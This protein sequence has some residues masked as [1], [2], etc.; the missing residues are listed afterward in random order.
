MVLPIVALVRPSSLATATNGM[1]PAAALSDVGP[2]GSL[3]I[4]AARAWKALCAAAK[5]AGWN[6]TYTYGG[7]YRPYADQERLFLSRYT[8]TF[9]PAAN[10]TVDSRMWRGARW[11]KRLGVAAAASPGTSNHGWGLAVDAALDF[12]VTD[13]IG[14]DDAVAITPALT[15][16]IANAQRF[17]WSWELQSEPW[18]IR[19]VAGDKVPQ[20]VLDYEAGQCFIAPLPYDPP[21]H[22]FGDWPQ[23]PKPVLSKG[24]TGLEV[25]YLQDVLRHEA[26][27]VIVTD[28][29]FGPKTEAEVI[30]FQ[31][32]FSI[33]ADGVVADQTWSAVD[34]I[35]SN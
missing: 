35:A 19:Y 33:E 4:T 15:W 16:L 31:R 34:F 14:P 5:I 11:Y 13:G 30:E 25:R 10:A 28:G 29:N 22:K 6:L 12:D 20:A 2:R 32:F 23:R 18:H 21:N 17:G 9:D 1:L 26:N 3:E 8:P 27:R 24:S 7:C